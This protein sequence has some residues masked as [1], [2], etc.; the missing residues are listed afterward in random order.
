[1]T[2]EANLP[3][4]D[5]IMQVLAHLGI[6]RAHFA[7]RGIPD[8][9]GIVERHPDAVASLTLMTP[10]RIPKDAIEPIAPKVMAVIG[11]QGPM[12]LAAQEVMFEVLDA[13]CTTLRGYEVFPWTDAAKDRHDAVLTSVLGFLERSKELPDLNVTGQAS[14]QVAGVSYTIAGSGPPLVLLPLGLSPSQWEPIMPGLSEHYTTVKLGGAYLGFVATLED[15]GRIPDY[16]NMFKG[17]VETVQIQPGELVLDVGSGS[18]NLD[19]WLL[20]ETKGA[21]RIIGADISPYLRG[22]ATALADSEGLGELIE[23][24]EGSA[25]ALPHADNTFDVTMSVTAMEEVDAD[26]MMAEVVRVTKPGGRIAVIVRS[27]DKP[28]VIE[29]P[30][31]DELR[32]KLESPGGTVA[33]KGC[34]DESLYARFEQAGLSDLQTWLYRVES[35]ATAG[36]MADNAQNNM[37]RKIAPEEGVVFTEAIAKAASDGT[38]MY[39]QPYHCA[40]GTV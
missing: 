5:R 29:I 20:R 15:R 34:A 8:W 14:G 4:D 1:M 2:T 3:T 12:S 36:P 18:G 22:E 27:V 37:L 30:V 26:K 6:E 11:D 28:W 21:N 40:V 32:A 38:L 31:L 10:D 33:P 19:R 9:R 24:R 13:S 17:L 7:A 16:V 23:F 39:A 35:N 25:E